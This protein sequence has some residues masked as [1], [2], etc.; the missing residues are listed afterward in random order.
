MV[1]DGVELGVEQPVNAQNVIGQYCPDLVPR[2]LRTARILA[3]KQH[4]S[5]ELISL[6][7]QPLSQPPVQGAHRRLTSVLMPATDVVLIDKSQ[8]G[9]HTC[10]HALQGARQALIS[11]QLQESWQQDAER[12]S[13]L[14]S[15]TRGASMQWHCR[16]RDCPALHAPALSHPPMGTWPGFPDHRLQRRSHSSE[17]SDLASFP[18]LQLP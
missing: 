14:P 5:L 2:P 16:N 8:C 12:L 11:C 7:N 13:A 3:Q 10:I 18:H 15:A 1:Q 4:Q 9:T 17:S 6:G